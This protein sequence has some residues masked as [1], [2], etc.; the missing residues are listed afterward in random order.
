MFKYDADICKK[1]LKRTIDFVEKKT[2]FIDEYTQ[3]RL[4]RHFKDFVFYSS[5]SYLITPISKRIADIYEICGLNDQLVFTQQMLF[6]NQDE[7]KTDDE[8][9]DLVQTLSKKIHDYFKLAIRFLDTT[10][11]AELISDLFYRSKNIRVQKKQNLSFKRYDFITNAFPLFVYES[12]S[13]N[14][15]ETLL[16]LHTLNKIVLSPK[17]IDDDTFSHIISIKDENL[18]LHFLFD[19]I[20]VEDDEKSSVKEIL[21]SNNF[22]LEK[23]ALYLLQ[24]MNLPEIDDGWP[25]FYSFLPSVIEKFYKKHPDLESSSTVI[26]YRLI[27]AKFIIDFIY[28]NKYE[29]KIRS[30]KVLT[31]LIKY[32]FS[33]INFDWELNRTVE[34]IQPAFKESMT[35]IESFIINSF[36]DQ[37]V[38]SELLERYI[39]YC[40]NQS[41]F[42]IGK[43]Y[44]YFERFSN[45]FYDF[46]VNSETTGLAFLQNITEKQIGTFEGL[47]LKMLVNK[48]KEKPDFFSENIVKDIINID[49]IRLFDTIEQ[50]FET[51]MFLGEHTE[52]LKE[53]H[54]E[55]LP[56]E[57]TDEY[58][59]KI[60]VLSASY[61]EEFKDDKGIKRYEELFKLIIDRLEMFKGIE[62]DLLS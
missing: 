52:K 32:F 4:D 17:H 46:I 14:R 3:N 61:L 29:N 38:D 45:N 40:Y 25:N 54:S 1:Q 43:K 53:I 39:N 47:S 44:A 36:T 7:I 9:A 11:I 48:F 37:I 49:R 18:F 28:E 30:T 21:E 58:L 27:E 15:A 51:T 5:S 41:T 31:G 59:K 2:T 10:V 22:P 8:V 12:S 20:T 56:I 23:I 16:L 60:K 34:L 19:K 62:S 50:V 35:R 13:D 55:L 24:S 33:V 6:E 57:T 26:P 42:I